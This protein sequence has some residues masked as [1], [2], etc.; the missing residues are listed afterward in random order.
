MGVWAFDCSP[1]LRKYYCRSLPSDIVAFLRRNQALITEGRLS[2]SN[3]RELRYD[4]PPDIVC[5][6]SGLLKQ[7]SFNP[8]LRELV[9]DRKTCGI[10][11]GCDRYKLGLRYT[12]R[13]MSG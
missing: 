6:F 8:R 2:S 13:L 10:Y 7:T 3:V 11:K 12:V 4:E 9:M 1:L 5:L